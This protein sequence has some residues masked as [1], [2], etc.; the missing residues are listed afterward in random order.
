MHF[1][2]SLQ[3]EATQA[4]VLIVPKPFKRFAI[5]KLIARNGWANCLLLVL[6]GRKGVSVK[7]DMCS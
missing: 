2:D 1:E 6:L 7:Q 5:V 4:G 3:Q